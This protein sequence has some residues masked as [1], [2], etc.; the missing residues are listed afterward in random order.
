MF[1]HELVAQYG[2]LVVFLSVLGSSLGLPVPAMPTLIT[3]GASITIAISTRSSAVV[4][5]AA[6]WGAA[7]LGGVLGDIVWYQGGKRF[8]ERTLQTVCSLTLSRDKCVRKTER[9]FGRWGVRI[10][11]VARFVPGLS[12]VA[13]PM[14]GAMAVKM[15]YFIA[16]DCAGVG[17]WAAVALAVGGAFA[18]QIE[19]I[20]KVISQLG[21]RALIV[22]AGVLALYI[23]YRYCRRLM[24]S[25]ALETSRINAVELHGLLATEPRPIIFDIRSPERRTLDPFVIPGAVFADEREFG[26]IVR[27]YD[28]C[29][30]FVIYCS[31][32]G[33]VSA[34][35]MAGRLRRAGIRLALPLSGGIDAWR[36]AGFN[37]APVKSATADCSAR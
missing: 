23:C 25:K 35:W 10:L 28:A 19:R 17:L 24:L 21:W 37:V 6:M 3:V 20:F 2:V 36:D 11:L 15:R 8:G 4:H 27:A 29:E 22:V 31:C 34:A 32:P 12:L 16:W 9:F 33:E 26:E 7:A 1:S 13:V 5:L 14:C 30:T 18:A